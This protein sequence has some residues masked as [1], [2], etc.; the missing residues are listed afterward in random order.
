[1]SQLEEQA[2]PIL[3]RLL[4]ARRAGGTILIAP[5]EGEILARWA[6]KTSWTSELAA[7]GD[8]NQDRTW[9]P[10]AMRRDLAAGMALPTSARVWLATCTDLDLCQ[11]IQ[12]QVSYD[13]TSPA[14]LGEQPRRILASCLIL[15][16]VALLV[17][18]FDHRASFPPP[19]ARLKGLLLHP[20]WTTVEF[21]SPV[22]SPGELHLAM[23]RYTPWLAVHKRPFD[24]A[25]SLPR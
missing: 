1:M 14:P 6:T 10:A 3:R 23:G 13:R 8:H 22:V 7:L 16:G 24:H 9:L 17:Y 20:Q 11:Q 2:R 5:R 25:A 4:N 12:A 21:P 18:H 19:L 15:H